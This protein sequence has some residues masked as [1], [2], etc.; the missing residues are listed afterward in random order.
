MKCC[1]LCER[2]GFPSLGVEHIISVLRHS[3]YEVE[4]VFDELIFQPWQGL[5]GSSS[6]DTHV[7]KAIIDTNCDVL[8]ASSTT[9]SFKRIENLFSMVRAQ[10]PDVVTC[11]GGPHATYAHEHVVNKPAIDFA[12]RGEGE[13]AVLE[14]LDMLKGERE[15]LPSGIYRQTGDVIEG[16]GFGA[17]VSNLDDLPYADKADFYAKVASVRS[18]YTIT[19]GRGCYNRCT[20]CNSATIRERYRDEGFNFGRRRSVDD[21]IGELVLAKKHYKPKFVWFCDDTFIHNKK[22][23]LDFGKRYRDEVGIPFGCSTIPN[24]FD[25]EVLDLLAEAGLKNVEVGVQTLN[26]ETRRNV[27]G[28]SET[29]EQFA[30]F[31]R[32]LRDRGVYVNTDHILNPW[33]SRESLVEQIEL[34]S[35]IRPSFINVFHLQYFPDTRVID[36]AIE[37]GFLKEEDRFGIGEGTEETYFSGGSIPEVL[38]SLH[39]LIVLLSFAPFL[40]KWLTRQILKNRIFLAMF[41]LMPFRIVLPLRAI[42]ALLRPADAAG[43]SRIKVFL[44]SLTGYEAKVTEKQIEAIRSISRVK[45][46]IEINKAKSLSRKINTTDFISEKIRRTEPI[47]VEAL[48]A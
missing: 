25:E 41:R 13:I 30:R 39:D 23:M 16:D 35:H 46:G 5:A 36:Y 38:D 33:D 27:F 42:S 17:L 26:E 10:S 6:V 14:F 15:D 47:P 45:K 1:F 31:V 29:N 9:I 22:Y 20:F 18:S 32:L 40:P 11:V 28:R 43:R 12:C 37:S 21:V 3:G 34:Y 2:A 24:F 8:F 7:V 48:D 19:S 4:V 44:F